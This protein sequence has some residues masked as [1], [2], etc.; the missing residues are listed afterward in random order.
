VVAFGVARLGGI[1]RRIRVA[2]IVVVAGVAGMAQTCTPP[3]G[4]G[5]GGKLPPAP[6]GAAA[7]P[8]SVLF[9]GSPPEDAF[10]ADTP[11]PFVLNVGGTYYSYSTNSALSLF[12]IPNVPVLT[13]TDA[14]NWTVLGD[15]LPGPAPSWATYLPYAWS[16]SVLV[17]PAN[18]PNQRYVMY[19]VVREK[20]SG[21]QCIAVAVSASPGGPF[22]DVDT[23]PFVCQRE[24]F[25]SIDPS[26]FVQSNGTVHL[27]WASLDNQRAGGL[28]RIW[29]RQLTS[30][31]LGL[32]GTTVQLLSAQ[33]GSEA[34]VVENPTLLQTE[35]G[36]F[37]F[38]SQNLWPTANY[39]VGVA[40][41]S[42]PRSA[43]T[44]VYSTPVLASRGTML[45]PGSPAFFTGPAGDL[46]VAF[47][48]WTSPYV[49]YR[50]QGHPSYP[51][52]EGRRSLRTLPVTFPNGSPQ[53]G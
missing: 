15:A 7:A 16:P 2:S 45:G 27:I 35:S 36:L 5:G 24:R 12:I 42:S 14:V 26:T 4:G 33:G 30:N 41:C 11:D 18:P 38:Y 51:A 9:P 23:G 31:G 10:A 8:V 1:V 28:T 13:S 46:R 48:A 37:L 21:R 29:S 20:S 43:C 49:G 52:G 32:T 6:G 22:V 39:S 40:R 44:R 53:I 50:D 47:H 25:G 19:H 17:R 34:S 3:P